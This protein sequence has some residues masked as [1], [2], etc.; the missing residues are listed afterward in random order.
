MQALV[1]AGGKGTRLRPL[2]RSIPKPMAPVAGVPYLEHQLRALAAQG[3]V[4]IALLTGY[5]GERIEDHFGD[6]ARFGLRIRY[7]REETP[8]GTGGALR[9]ALPLLEETFLAIY[10]DSFLPVEYREPLELL[11]E[12][13]AEGVMA[14]CRDEA[15]ETGV[16]PNVALDAAGRVAR[17]AKDAEE[18]RDLEYIEAGVLAFRREAVV[19]IPDGRAVSLEAEVF[20]QLIARG[21]LLGWLSPRRF[22]DIGTPERLRAL[23]RLWA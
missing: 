13:G 8:L 14:V 19:G 6:G 11:R 23:E 9:R 20:P 1:L 4:D 15:G 17:Y 2:T 21:S 7:S 18:A 22:H 5:L 10:G 12:R 3:I 16:R